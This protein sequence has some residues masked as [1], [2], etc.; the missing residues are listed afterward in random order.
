M[1]DRIKDVR[2]ALKLTQDEFAGKLGLTRGAITNI[3]L[4][5]T[6]PKPLLVELICGTYNVNR[7]WL[8]TGEGSMFNDLSRNEQIAQF[9]GA[10]LGAGSD[11]F[12]LRFVEVLSKLSPEEWELMES[13]AKKL[14]GK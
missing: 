2:K 6:D 5:K 1:N 4:H 8:E 3:E 10:V 11:D 7:V 9:M 14:A 13:M 12:R